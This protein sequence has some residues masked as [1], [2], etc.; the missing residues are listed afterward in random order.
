MLLARVGSALAK[1]N[2]A[3]ASAS[4]GTLVRQVQDTKTSAMNTTRSAI[5]RG[6][7]VRQQFKQAQIP[8]GA[9]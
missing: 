2:I 6:K 7:D 8:K 3:G 4:A 9:R 1:G 5:E